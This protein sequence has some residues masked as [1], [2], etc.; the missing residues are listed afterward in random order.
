L[1]IPPSSFWT[2]FCRP[3][4]SGA[5]EVLGISRATADRYWAYAKVWL[6]CALSGEEKPE[7]S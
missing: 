4:G 6:Y 7:T 3:D 1:R 2:Q 5:A